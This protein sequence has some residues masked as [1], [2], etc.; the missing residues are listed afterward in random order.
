MRL[1]LSMLLVGCLA[2]ALPRAHAHAPQEPTGEPAQ[3]KQ[4]PSLEELARRMDEAHA[5]LAQPLKPQARD[6][7]GVGTLRDPAG[8]QLDMPELNARPGRARPLQIFARQ[9]LPGLAM[10]TTVTFL[11]WVLPPLI[12]AMPFATAGMV[13]ALGDYSKADGGYGATLLGGLAGFGTGFVAGVLIAN[14]MLSNNDEEAYEDEG[15]NNFFDAM[16]AISIA[17]SVGTTVGSIVGY[18]LSDHA[19]RKKRGER[20]VALG[21]RVAPSSNGASVALTGR[22]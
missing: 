11:S 19:V 12:L 20:R 22:F 6:D 5:Q 13:Y 18:N 15:W 21:G 7:G 1:A 9:L 3:A 16:I 4:E 10:A 2:F 14:A 8:H 17:A